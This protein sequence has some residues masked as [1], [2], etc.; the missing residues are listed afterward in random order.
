MAEE[1]SVPV[2]A[3]PERRKERK[4]GGQM[5]FDRE[6]QVM[7]DVQEALETLPLPARQRVLRWVCDRS[8]VVPL[9]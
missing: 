7:A 1:V 4:A 3:E 6:L 8:V 2:E 9:P 5:V